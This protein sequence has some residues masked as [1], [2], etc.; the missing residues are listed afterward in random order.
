MRVGRVGAGLVTAVMAVSLVQV[1]GLSGVDRAAAEPV[2]E[3]AATEQQALTQA[4][5]SGEPVEVLSRRGEHRTVRAL[6]TGRLELV[7][8]LRPVRTRQDGRWVDIDTKLRTSGSDVVPG[9]TTVGLRLSG[10]GDGPLVRMSRAGRELSLS[11]PEKLPEPTLDGDTAVYAGVLGSDIDL[12]VRAEPE[13]FAHTF[14][15]KT[16]EAAQDPRLATLAFKLNTTRLSVGTDAA[17]GLQAKDATSQAGVFEAPAP[18]MWDSTQPAPPAGRRAAAQDLAE[19]PAEGGQTAP[20][21]VGVANGQLTLKPDQGLLTSPDTTFPVYID[22]VW[23]TNAAY[24]W[25]MVSSGYP[26]ESY[27]KFSGNA[28]EGMGR[29]EVAKDPR[30]V[31]DQTKR[32]FYRMKLPSIKGSYIQ[33]TEFVAYET[34]AW[35]CENPTSVQLWRTSGLSSN[36]TWNNTRDN[37][38]EQLA[39]RDVAYCSRAPVEFG[40]ATLRSHVQD[41]VNKGYSTITLGLKAY[42][43]SSMAWWKRFADD[44]Y[45]KVQYNRPP[46]QPNTDSMYASPGTKCVDAPQAKPVNDLSTMYA[47]LWDPDTEDANKVQGEFA[48]NWDSGDGKGF[49]KRWTSPLLPPLTSGTKRYYKV[50]ST[51]PQKTLIAWN[52]RAFDGEQWGP[53]ASDGAQHACY[54]YYDPA[55]PAAPTVTSADYPGDDTWHGGVGEAGTFTISDAARVADRYDIS[56]NGTVIKSVAT[57][58]GA[59]RNVSLAPTRSGPNLLTVQAFTDASQNSS[60]A[61]YEFWAKAGADPAARFT[62][63]ENAGS[64][65]VA[66]Q[67]PGTAAT[68]KGGATLGGEGKVGAAL[69][70]NG[71]SGYAETGLPAVDTGQSFTVSAWLKPKTAGMYN[72]LAQDGAHQSGFQVGIEPSG[73]LAFKMP[74]ADTAANGGGSWHTALASAPAGL[75]TWTHV[76]GVYDATAHQL[77]LYLNGQREATVDGVTAWQA[78]GG[79]QIG[80]SKYNG[81][82]GNPWP[83]G[84]DDIKLFGQAVTDGDAQGLA[85]GNNPDGASPQ[86][87]WKLDEPAGS[88]RVYSPADLK[89]T[90][91]GGATLGQAGQDGTALRLNG[92]DGYAATP[93]PVVATH[94]SFAVAAWV[95]LDTKRGTP[96]VVSQEGSNGSAMALY[97]SAGSDRWEFNMQTPDGG[98]FTLINV[99]SKTPAVANAWTHLVG[100]Y[101]ATLGQISLYVNGELQQ[102]R[103]QPNNWPSTGPLN[104][105]R[106]RS[107]DGY[108]GDFYWPGTIDDLQ[109]YDRIVGPQEVEELVTQHPVL[110][111]RWT[112]NTDGSAEPAG[113]PAM[114]LAGGAAIDPSAGFKYI[115]AGGL[116]LNGTTA[117][118]QTTAPPIKTDESFTIAGWVRN[119]GRPQTRATVFSQAGI[120]TNAFALRYVPDTAD[121]GNVGG[122][123]LEMNNADQAGTPRTASHPGFNEWDWDHVAIVYDAL[124]DRMSL[125]V[126]GALHQSEGAVSQEDQVL[127]FTA[128]N[129][130]L[131]VGRTKFGATGGS[132]FWPD[133]ID[134]IWAYRGALTPNQVGRLASLEELAIGDGP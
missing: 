104:I 24:A 84:V 119:I 96:V 8:H 39:S 125:Y 116:L 1:L 19:G 30:C 28:T 20:V 72:A 87:H 22:P 64:T 40:G 21:Q 106:Y 114:T 85:A 5:E 48:L 58:D 128:A 103:A 42:S 61:T 60:P 107:V 126:N 59:A 86:A 63:N 68:V 111:A 108:G 130:G 62:L 50:P 95:R 54:F 70:L 83:G 69:N 124:R 118:A 18:I 7:E 120:N 26:D 49:I 2:P 51:I 75:D 89:A 16:A 77:R 115:S 102:T 112:F 55:V 133:A 14:V 32:L 88:S 98:T 127:G 117:H 17:G 12:R 44:A 57:T 91:H 132:E 56:L 94:R 66:A 6:P 90:P 27:Y 100:V 46:H 33:S 35:D 31:K 82:Y 13:G 134:D 23:Q 78:K 37:W 67:S 43:E 65:T 71:T 29:C 122:W 41:A 113:A 36:A 38:G 80:R 3:G 53:W 110:A 81:Q 101:D 123:Q 131:Q 9:A 93:G 4:R 105:G 99:L 97:Y 47:Y 129:G 52:V 15:V 79:L 74:S 76:T 73:R 45:L 11:W 121:P 34:S 92:T 25:A 109:I 10:G